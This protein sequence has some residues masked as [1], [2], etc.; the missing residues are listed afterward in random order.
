MG[1]EELKDK[2][3]VTT[4]GISFDKDGQ[5]HTETTTETT[6][7]DKNGNQVATRETKNGDAANRETEKLMGG[8]GQMMGGL[9]PVGAMM[10]IMNQM[11]R[12]RDPLEEL[13]DHLMGM[14]AAD[15]L[16]QR[17]P[18]RGPRFHSDLHVLGVPSGHV[19]SHSHGHVHDHAPEI[20]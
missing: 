18:S 20:N 16:A 15:V 12:P 17:R 11:F 8:L 1:E 5:M 3:S 19:H 10:E 4:M 14:S 13:I 6:G 9:G 2:R 7:I